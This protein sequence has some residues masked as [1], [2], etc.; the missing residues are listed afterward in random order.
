MKV[1]RTATG[2]TIK[3]DWDE[4]EELKDE[5]ENIQDELEETRWTH[6]LV[7]KIHHELDELFTSEGT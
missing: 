4:A 2:V 3:L 5:V 7:Y 1:E 6:C